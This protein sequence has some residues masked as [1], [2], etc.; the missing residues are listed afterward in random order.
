VKLLAFEE[1]AAFD[2]VVTEKGKTNPREA[3]SLVR[4]PTTER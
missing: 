3:A 2:Q 4:T 1:N